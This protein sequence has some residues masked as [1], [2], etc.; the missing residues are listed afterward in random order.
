[1][2]R[3][4][5]D[6]RAHADRTADLSSCAELF[7]SRIQAMDG[8]HSVRWRVKD[9][10]HLMEKVVRKRAADKKRETEYWNISSANYQTIVTDLIG[11][12]ALHLLKADALKVHARIHDAWGLLKI[13]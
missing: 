11:I 13:R 3:S 9:S 2:E 10:I 4:L 12:R 8:V 5:A 6:W 7:S 1:M